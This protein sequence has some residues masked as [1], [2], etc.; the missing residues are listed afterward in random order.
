MRKI[1]A[2]EG[3]VLTQAGDIQDDKRLFAKEVYLSKFD[4]PENWT[5]WPKAEAYSWLVER[6]RQDEA[7]NL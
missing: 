1:V 3:F 7:D 5:T 6:G 2:P 4:K